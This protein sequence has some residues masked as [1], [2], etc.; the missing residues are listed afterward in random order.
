ME[1]LVD[2]LSRK[3]FE[4]RDLVLTWSGL[5]SVN[6]DRCDDEFE[7][8]FGGDNKVC[9]V[10]SILAEF[11]CPKVALTRKSD[12]CCSVYNLKSSCSDLFEAIL[13]SLRAGRAFR[14]EASNFSSLLRLSQ[15][16]ENKELLCSLMGGID[17]KSMTLEEGL[18]VLQ[19]GID[20]GIASTDQFKKLTEFIASHFYEIKKEILENI[21][22]ETAQL[23]LSSSSLRIEDEDSVYDFVRSRSETDLS[24][25]SLFEFVYFEYLSKD[26][27]EDFARFAKDNLLE[28][29]SEGIWSRIC[30]RLILDSKIGKKSPRDV[31]PPG[32]EFP[33]KES[34]PLNGIIAHLTREC[35]GNVHDKG[36]VNITASSVN[37]S[38]EEKRNAVDFETNTYFVSQNTP[39]SWICYDF[40]DSRVSPTSYSVRSCAYGPGSNHPKSWVFEVSNDETNWT[41]VD[42]RDNNGD[43]NNN[44]VTRNFRLSSTSSESFRFVRLRQTGKTHGGRDNLVL[45]ALEIFGFLTDK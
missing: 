35:G 42:R 7:F 2:T 10:H 38:S 8:V 17:M 20:L 15:E 44:F 29:I 16:L 25:S 6:W 18:L 39:N 33:Y 9:R 12:G 19:A 1:T 27:V 21:N 5:G 22:F 45:S 14:V 36:I 11:L 41:V 13:S 23:L 30:C 34:D 24:F 40:K 37:S 26:R 32:R 28:N 3:G 31:K 4:A 43:L